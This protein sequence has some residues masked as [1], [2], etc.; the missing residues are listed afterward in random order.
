MPD[1]R[2]LMLLQDQILR[3]MWPE[4]YLKALTDN[5]DTVVSLVG[6]LQCTKDLMEQ[7]QSEQSKSRQQSSRNM[8][9]LSHAVCQEE[10][11]N[12]ARCARKAGSESSLATLIGL[13]T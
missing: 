11:L 7:M 8:L 13:Q 4:R 10:T 2:S 6:V 12:W 9:C 3:G 1:T 5:P